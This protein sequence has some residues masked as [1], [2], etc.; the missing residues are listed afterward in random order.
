M[1]V[2]GTFAATSD[3]GWQGRIRTLTINVPAKIVP[4]DNRN[5]D[6]APDYLVVSGQSEIGAAWARLSK[7]NPA[8]QY[9]SVQLDDP[10]LQEPISAVLCFLPGGDL[11]RLVWSRHRD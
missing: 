5:S 6:K 3:G 2:I 1:A 11:A 8:R 4:N 10:C 7:D 9:F